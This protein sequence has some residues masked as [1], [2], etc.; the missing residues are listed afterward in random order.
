M[1][2]VKWPL[3]AS[4]HISPQQQI[5]AFIMSVM[6]CLDRFAFSEQFFFLL[7]R[8]FKPPPKKTKT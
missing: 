2:G 4:T 7:Y 8:S 6:S 5:T 3:Q 1:T